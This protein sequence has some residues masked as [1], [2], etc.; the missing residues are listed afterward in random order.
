LLKPENRDR[1][2]AIL[3]YHVVPASIE[4]KDVPNRRTQVQTLN[5]AARVTVV[6]S[7]GVVHVD[8]AR[9]TKANIR[10]DNGIIHVINRV[11]IP[12]QTP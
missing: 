7:K 6:R 8:K 1:L 12:G 2:R 10:A 3:T 9:V 5:P 11:L 4:A